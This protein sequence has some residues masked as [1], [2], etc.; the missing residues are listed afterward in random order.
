MH[1]K[2]ILSRLTLFLSVSCELE[3]YREEGGGC[4]NPLYQVHLGT[5]NAPISTAA[6]CCL[7]GTGY[8]YHDRDVS[9]ECTQCPGE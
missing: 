6:E 9:A 2:S 1:A 4:S 3:C 8:W 5:D 7:I